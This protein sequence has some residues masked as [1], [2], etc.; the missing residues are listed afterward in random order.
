M[1]DIDLSGAVNAIGDDNADDEGSVN[2]VDEADD[3]EDVSSALQLLG[4]TIEVLQSA[5]GSGDSFSETRFQNALTDHIYIFTCV[6]LQVV[7]GRVREMADEQLRAELI[8]SAE[9]T[10]SPAYY[11]ATTWPPVSDG[12]RARVHAAR[13][14]MAD[15]LQQGGVL[16]PIE[17]SDEVISSARA[18]I[19]ALLLSGL[20]ATVTA[21]RLAASALPAPPAALQTTPQAEPAFMQPSASCP[22][23]AE[24]SPPP[25]QW[26]SAP[27]PLAEQS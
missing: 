13:Q 20:T 3:A 2:C 22:L 21:S 27:A 11:W 15:F 4:S 17:T 16:S 10:D 26:A 5:R 9:E 1:S 25:L 19:N 7:V 12:M 23:P 8:V 6:A 24:A 14:A 18:R